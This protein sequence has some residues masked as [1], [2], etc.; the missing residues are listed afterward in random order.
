MLEKRPTSDITLSAL[1]NWKKLPCALT[2]NDSDKQSFFIV[3]GGK[4]GRCHPCFIN[5]K[6]NRGYPCSINRS[7]GRCYPRTTIE[8][9]MC[10]W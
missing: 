7:A 10:R 3:N 2:P 4:A 6:A 5:S 1:C 9:I 8:E